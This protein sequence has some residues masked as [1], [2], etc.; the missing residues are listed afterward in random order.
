MKIVKMALPANC[1][2][3]GVFKTI[4]TMLANHSVGIH[5]DDIGMYHSDDIGAEF[6]Y[7]GKILRM[8]NTT[9]FAAFKRVYECEIKSES[10]GVWGDNLICKN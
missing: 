3:E 10:G 8:Y 6:L 9:T 5:T 7:D 1:T 4:Q 2:L